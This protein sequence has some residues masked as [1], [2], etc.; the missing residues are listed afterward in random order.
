LGMG[1]EADITNAFAVVAR[2]HRSM[3]EPALLAI[4]GFETFPYQ[5]QQ[6]GTKLS[7]E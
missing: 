2:L 6:C 3:P 1:S 5:G 4:W 7:S